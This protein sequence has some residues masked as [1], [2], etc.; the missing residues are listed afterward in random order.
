MCI[1]CWNTTIQRSVLVESIKSTCVTVECCVFATPRLFACVKPKYYVGTPTRC[2]PHVTLVWSG[3]A[4]L[5]T[6]DTFCSA[7]PCL[8][9]NHKLGATP[10]KL[11]SISILFFQTI[12]RGESVASLP[13]GICTGLLE[14]LQQGTVCGTTCTPTQKSIQMHACP[15]RHLSVC[16]HR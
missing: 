7:T 2:S 12:E 15:F 16:Q 8:D 9:T 13:P 3:V 6:V 14:P 10:L 11:P 1:V 5:R 4:K